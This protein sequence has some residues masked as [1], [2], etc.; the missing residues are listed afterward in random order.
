MPRKKHQIIASLIFGSL[1]FLFLIFVFIFGPEHLPSFKHKILAL[2]S[3]TLAGFFSFFLSGSIKVSGE[4]KLPIFGRLAFRATG[5]VGVFVLVLF[6]WGSEHAPIKLKKI[7]AVVPF[8]ESQDIHL[9]DNIYPE[10]WGYS[11]NP[12]HNRIY[13][14]K[15]KGIIYF[16]KES[17]SFLSGDDGQTHIGKNFVNYY[18][19]QISGF[20]FSGYKFVSSY[21]GEGE[22]PHEL[23]EYIQK[24]ESD[25][26]FRIDPMTILYTNRNDKGDYYERYAALSIIYSTD[27]SI[28]LAREGLEFNKE[29]ISKVVFIIEFYHGG[30]RVGQSQN[31]K[32]LINESVY[33][34]VTKSRN[35]REKE[36]LR[37]KIDKRSLNYKKAN[38]VGIFVLP[39]VEERPKSFTS[40]KGPSHFR[41]VGIINAYF[42][43]TEA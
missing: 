17:G 13:P 18:R 19:D 20:D 23:K 39:W 27:F 1:T 22:T 41:D 34:L 30:I 7:Q 15:A 28:P 35:M 37:V 42:L 38:I 40:N 9:G 29:Q 11:H 5:G 33:K 36:I 4:P 12:L 8:I 43:I 10:R 16:D 6:W 2:L 25:R 26:F 32:L 14:Q 21:Q 3:A 24:K 31:F